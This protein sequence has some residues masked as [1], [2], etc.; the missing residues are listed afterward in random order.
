M[1][2]SQA[3]DYFSLNTNFFN[4]DKIQL[5]EAEFG[6][7]GSYIALRLLCKIYSTEGYYYRWGGDECL[8]FAKSMGAVFVPTM[9][10]EVVNG[11]VKRSFFDK[12]VFDTFGILTSRGIQT[13]YFQ[14]VSRRQKVSVIRDFL[15]VDVSK[16]NNVYIIDNDVNIIAQNVDIIPQS[17]VKESK[18]NNPPLYSNEYIPPLQGETPPKPSRKRFVRPTVDEV[19]AYCQE[20]GNNVDAQRFLD[21]YESK[22]WKVGNSPMKDWKA[23]VRTWEQRDNTPKQS[24]YQPKP[25]QQE[26]DW[27]ELERQRQDYI[28]KLREREQKE[29]D[30]GI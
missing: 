6:V 8:L 7:K 4:D 13:R 24:P 19:R 20:R 2:N 14:A 22:G 11:L 1:L 29:K 21:F 5:I 23:C 10:N 26:T 28:R 15:L 30:N 18:V 27:D 9:V 16:M 25:Q 12:R 17:K 3:I